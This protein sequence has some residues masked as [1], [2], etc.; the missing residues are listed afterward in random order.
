MT[1]K[2]Q[3]QSAGLCAGDGY[4][5]QPGCRCC[6][7]KHC[8]RSTGCLIPS[9]NSSTGCLSPSLVHSHQSVWGLTAAAAVTW[10]SD[11]H[12]AS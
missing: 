10:T 7:L 9:H 1:T 3:R 8:C 12:D 6:C 5:P 11:A 4:V 2:K